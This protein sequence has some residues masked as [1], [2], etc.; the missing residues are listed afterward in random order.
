[1]VV[2]E[3]LAGGVNSAAEESYASCMAWLVSNFIKSD[4]FVHFLIG[5]STQ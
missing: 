1:M 3:D 2:N 4:L 5:L